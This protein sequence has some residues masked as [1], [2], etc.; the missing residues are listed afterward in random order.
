MSAYNWRDND[1][2]FAADWDR[3]KELGLEALE[4][5]ATRRA[6]DGVDKAVVYQGEITTTVKE[7]S[8]TLLIFLLKGGKPQKYRDRTE[9]SGP[10]GGPLEIT[11]TE[12]SA[13]VA[14]LLALA[15][16]RADH[17]PDGLT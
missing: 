16:H 11:E 5:E 17:D 15:Q 3:A 14:G 6:F 7:Y 9:L 12:R 4:D 10:G 8:D 13:R 2:N 1:P